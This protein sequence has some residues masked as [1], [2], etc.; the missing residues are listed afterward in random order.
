M[1]AITFNNRP[2]RSETMVFIRLPANSAPS[3]IWKQI[4]ESDQH[5]ADRQTVFR[6]KRMR[7]ESRGRDGRRRGRNNT[8]KQFSISVGALCCCLCLCVTEVAAE[9]ENDRDCRKER[10]ERETVKKRERVNGGRGCDNIAEKSPVCKA[11]ISPAS[12]IF[13]TMLSLSG[14]WLCT[15]RRSSTGQFVSTL[16]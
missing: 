2:A 10:T 14:C 7:E 3:H 1:R 12:P 9:L 8:V 11:W 4:L 16:P 13:D 5:V 6:F 15:R